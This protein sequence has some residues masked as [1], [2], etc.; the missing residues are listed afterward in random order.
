MQ[1]KSS[2]EAKLL[3]R[4]CCESYKNPKGKLL[5]VCTDIYHI[6][7]DCT[8]S[9]DALRYFFEKTEELLPG[10]GYENTEPED[11]DQSIKRQTMIHQF[12]SFADGI[13]YSL[14][15]D[16]L[17][18]STFYSKLWNEIDTNPLLKNDD[19]RVFALYYILLDDLIPYYQLNPNFNVSDEDLR[20]CFK[21]LIMKLKKIH[22]ISKREFMTKTERTTHLLEVLDSIE[23]KQERIVLLMYIIEMC[24]SSKDSQ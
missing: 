6:L 14:V 2:E 5:N 10:L 20:N 23:D 15:Y 11:N 8:E 13:L 24:S 17:D 21:N 19:V 3:I 1:G 22:Y 9:G 12:G 7:K 4:D 16:N 18:E